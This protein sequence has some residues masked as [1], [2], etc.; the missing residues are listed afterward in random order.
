M[1]QAEMSAN[2]VGIAD[3]KTLKD[4]SA[5]LIT[6]ALG[7]CVG[8]AMYDPASSVGGLLHVLLPESSLDAVKAANNP[9]MFAD[10]GVAQLVDRC[11]ALGAVK[12]RMRVW[13]AGGSAVFD[14]NGIFKIGKRNQ[15]AARKALWKAGLLTVSEDLGGNGYRTVRLELQTGTF[16]IR[17]AG[18]DQEL[19]PAASLA[20]GV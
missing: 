10:T 3:C 14:Q 13:L 17:A 18:E 6:Y 16:W 12:S 8:V 9:W 4:R 7:S 2:V 15:L 11:L 5:T 20:K 19:K 1:T